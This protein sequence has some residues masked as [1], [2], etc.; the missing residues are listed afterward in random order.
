MLPNP[1]L[2]EQKLDLFKCKT[3]ADNIFKIGKNDFNLF[4][5]R[6]HCAKRETAGYQYFLQCGFLK[7]FSKALLQGWVVWY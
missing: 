6:E 3:S 5:I 4:D 1:F 2:K 7:M